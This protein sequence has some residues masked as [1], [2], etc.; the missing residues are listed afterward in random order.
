[1]ADTSQQK[2]RFISLRIKLVAAFLVL[3]GVL[4]GSIFCWF[5][6][7]S[8]DLVS[9]Q[10]YDFTTNAAMDRLQEDMDA[11]LT[12]VS[13]QI[14]ADQF[15]AL[16]AD[17]QLAAQARAQEDTPDAGIY[18]DDERYLNHVR[19]LNTI[20]RSD[21]R[22]LLYTYVAGDSPNTIIW[23]GSGGAL[24]PTPAGAKFR[25]VTHFSPD[26]S[27]VILAGLKEKTFYLR[28]YE[29]EFGNWVS[30]YAP[31]YDA[32]GQAVGGLGVD[33]RAEYVERVQHD[34]ENGITEDVQKRVRRG[35]LLASG[36]TT[37]VV[38]L[39]VLGIAGVLT[40]PITILTRAAKRI[41]ED[42]YDQDLHQLTTPPLSDEIST[43][44]NVFEVMVNKIRQR[45]ERFK[46]Q[47]GELQIMID[48]GKAQEQV[49]E[50]VDS[51]FFRDLDHPVH[52]SSEDP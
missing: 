2:T 7:F 20:S 31:I 28:V 27:A 4:T 45:E 47:V 19:L 8:D 43:L 52:D 35:I 14:D 24:D 39:M 22:R 3:Y 48:E 32:S 46:K 17:R 34:L 10:F 23:I 26:D 5:Y 6:T 40:R 9:R 41:S 51:D 33:F 50:I 21:P 44:A 11:L 15:A 25:Q 30:G 49:E 13:A 1:M 16:V 18:P 37:T 42:D 36:I 12:G 29:D 38:V